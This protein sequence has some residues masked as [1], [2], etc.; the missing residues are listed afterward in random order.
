[1]TGNRFFGKDNAIRIKSKTNIMIFS[2][3]LYAVKRN[4]NS[5]LQHH[6]IQLIKIS[7]YKRKLSKRS[8]HI[9]PNISYTKSI[10]SSS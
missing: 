8:A 4:G 10:H 1:M 2:I 5:G 3:S 6:Y 9:P 7:S